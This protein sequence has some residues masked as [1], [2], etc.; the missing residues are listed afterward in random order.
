MENKTS[1]SHENANLCFSSIFPG[2][3]VV[4][5]RQKHQLSSHYPYLHLLF[6]AK[7]YSHGRNTASFLQTKDPIPCQLHSMIIY[8]Y[9]LMRVM[10]N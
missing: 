9:I 1:D 10:I 4:Y 7:N 2:S 5:N 8:K 3:E 6:Y